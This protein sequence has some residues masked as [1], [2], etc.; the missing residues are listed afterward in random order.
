MKGAIIQNAAEKCDYS[1]NFL[2][3]YR[4]KDSFAALNGKLTKPL[5]EYKPNIVISVRVANIPMML[6][7]ART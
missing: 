5:T 2:M 3:I 1:F 4:D 7:P 6:K